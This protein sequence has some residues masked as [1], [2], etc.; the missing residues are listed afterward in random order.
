MIS[1]AV[2][3]NILDDFQPL[4]KAIKDSGLNAL[5]FDQNDVFC[6]RKD[7]KCSFVRDGLPLHR[8]EVHTSEYASL[9]LQDYFSEWSKSNLPSIFESLPNT[10]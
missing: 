1:S 9:L 4:I 7:G 5:V 8:D 2:R 3:K 6:D 10:R